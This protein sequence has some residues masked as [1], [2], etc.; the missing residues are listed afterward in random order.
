[1]Y[2][3]LL[4]AALVLF[5]SILLINNR[6]DRK[7]LFGVYSQPGKWYFIKY[8]VMLGLLVFRRLQYYIYGKEGFFDEKQLERRR[9][10]SNHPLAF[11]AIFFHAVSQDDVYVVA[12]AE[13]R[14]AGIINGLIYIKHP[15]FGLL[16][17]PK[18][19]DTKLNEDP[20]AIMSGKEWAAEGFKFTPVEPMKR[21][22]LSYSGKMRIHGND[23]KLVQVDMQAKFV[24]DL[25]WF[26][27]ETDIPAKML[28]HS[29]AIEPWTNEYFQTL[30]EAHQS[31]YEQQG[32]LEGTLK[33]DGKEVPLKLDAFRD[34]SFG[35]KR[36]W[37]L[38]HRYIFHMFYLKN[39]TRIVLGVISQP[40][41]SSHMQMGYVVHANGKIDTIDTCD[42]FL[43]Q[44][45]EGGRPSDDLCFTFV[46][47]DHIYE[48]KVKYDSTV[49]HFVGENTLVK[50]YERF[51]TC[52]VNGIKG[53]GISEWN[54]SNTNGKFNL[55]QYHC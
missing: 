23:D 24:S 26:I 6:K 47:A 31:H 19:P 41:S 9:P 27:Y 42:L 13:R 30:K 38:M 49:A 28:A 7:K 20:E 51:L 12:G 8:P 3:D 1:M 55:N 15:E 46:A 34:H 14:Q 35:E 50:M 39:Q 43:W 40:C 37:S 36:D 16:K 21:W 22:D 45:G 4:A 18:L 25:P 11:D 48:C 32:F 10:L 2:M 53:K 33:V 52:E 5:L 17:T 44:H 29:F 54:Y